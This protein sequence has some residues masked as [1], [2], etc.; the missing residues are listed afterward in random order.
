VNALNN[1]ASSH[2]S[3]G[4]NSSAVSLYLERAIQIGDDYMLTKVFANLGSHLSRIGDEDGAADAFIKSFWLCLKQN[5]V[6]F[7]IGLLARRAL[8]IPT[9]SNSIAQTELDRIAFE[10]RIRDV[11]KL[12]RVGGSNYWNN[13]D[14]GDLF[15]L[16]SGASNPDDIRQIPVLAGKLTRWSDALQTPHF[17]V[18][19]KG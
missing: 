3:E 2:F 1:L 8:L 9:I 18:H 19:Y 5:D 17:F 11:T 14:K 13:E 6:E 12:A 10:Q 16:Q 15:R 4:K 7:A